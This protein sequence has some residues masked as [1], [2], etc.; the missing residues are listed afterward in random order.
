MKIGP[1]DWRSLRNLAL[2]VLVLGLG[3]SVQASSA[4]VNAMDA[5]GEVQK[6]EKVLVFVNDRFA[7]PDFN[8]ERVREDLLRNAFYDA[9]RRSNWAGNYKFVY[10]PIG[11][12]APPGSI[13]FNVM[14]WRRSHSGMYQFTASASYWN[15]D[16]EKVNLGS[17]NGTRTSIAVF[18]SWDVGDQFSGSAKD[19]FRSALRKLEKETADA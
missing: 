2:G 15:S 9:S 6:E 18:N 4:K 14:S 5:Q 16:G 17:F 8:S 7:P 10:N 19:A 11:K 1:F 12:D 13:E 3:W